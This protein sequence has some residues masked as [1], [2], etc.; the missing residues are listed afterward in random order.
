MTGTEDPQ[1]PELG[2]APSEHVPPWLGR[3]FEVTWSWVTNTKLG[4]AVF[5]AAI[6]VM[7]YGLG[8]LAVGSQIRAGGDFAVL[9]SLALVASTFASAQPAPT[10]AMGTLSLVLVGFM[11]AYFDPLAVGVLAGAAATVG[12]VTSYGV[13]ATGVGRLLIARLGNRP[14]IASTIERA[15]E[16]TRR[17]GPWAVLMFAFVPNPLYAW[18]SVAAGASKT[19][20]GR[21]F[22]AAA[23]G[24]FTRFILVALL[25]KGI[26][27][28][29][30]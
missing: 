11:G 25:G 15:F 1:L 4:L 30:S 16:V 2:E 9:A 20:F 17:Y 29:L 23:T 6:Y 14:A 13:G 18:S 26:E 10:P 8:L 19:K 21:Y 5:V 22:A 12:L 27:K 24:S 3:F 7:P 28:I